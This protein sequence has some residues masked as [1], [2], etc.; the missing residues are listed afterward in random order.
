VFMVWWFYICHFIFMKRTIRSENEKIERMLEDL[1]RLES[2]FDE[3][4]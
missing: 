4:Q 1:A 3:P 2:Q